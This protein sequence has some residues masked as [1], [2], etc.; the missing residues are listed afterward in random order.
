MPRNLLSWL[1]EIFSNAPHEIVRVKRQ[2]N[3]AQ[4]ESAAVLDALERQNR[5]EAVLFDSVTDLKGR[6]TD[7]KLLNNT[8]ATFAKIGFALGVDTSERMP[9]LERILS[10]SNRTIPPQ[11]IDKRDAPVKR[12][13]QSGH[14]LDLSLLP[15][16]R[17]TEMD[18]GPYLTPIVAS[19]NKDGRYNVSWNRMMYLD[20]THLAIYMSPRHLWSYF[21]AAEADKKDLPI[22]VV[23]GHHPAFHMTG[24]LLSPHGADEY[25]A[26]GGVLGEPLRVTQSESF[27]DNL[28]VPAEAE[29][30]IEGRILAR[31]RVVEGPFG[32]FTGY[33]GAQRLSWVFEAE[34]ITMRKNPI[35]IDIFP[36]KTE[37][38]NAHLPIEA[39]IYARA[40]EAVPNVVKT[41]WV[42]SGGPFN[43]IISINKKT[44][45][46][47]MRAAMAAVSASNFIKHVIVVDSDIDP[48]NMLE[49]MWAFSS[50][51]QADQDVTLLKNLQGQILD[52]SLRHEI[53][54]SGM[55]IDATRP[56]DRPFP[57]R[58][59]VPE[60][61]R[62]KLNL[63]D[64]L[65]D[66]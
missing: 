57:Q 16:I 41:C 2:V 24:A 38:M 6:P 48:E 55:I 52:P 65:E 56:L 22:A 8:F 10:L 32:E 15:L 28:L 3:P 45:G 62:K 1:D 21:A 60:H 53:K 43:L 17:H 31:K 27:G 33:T 66:L 13:V 44:E 29:L 25:E 12:I 50:R 9:I 7:C 47:P 5:Y 18:G 26:T 46:E 19:K 35:I 14:A 39:S 61:I 36:C 20:R 58:G 64:Y 51:V 49:V 54:S 23:L 42:G 63:S 11:L 4:F 34:A 37:H 59:E 30:I 40:K